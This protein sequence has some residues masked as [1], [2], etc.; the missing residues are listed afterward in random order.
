MKD[1][2]DKLQYI[3]ITE[4]GLTLDCLLTENDLISLF[5]RMV[6]HGLIIQIKDKFCLPL[7]KK[8]LKPPTTPARSS[9]ESW[10]MSQ[11][12]FVN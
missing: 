7:V 4:H 9:L 1:I 11:Y 3:L 5:N 8:V 12:T 6:Q 2:V 10:S